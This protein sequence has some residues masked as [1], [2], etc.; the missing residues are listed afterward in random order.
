MY[1]RGGD[2]QEQSTSLVWELGVTGCL[3]WAE[4]NSGWKVTHVTKWLILMVSC[5]RTSVRVGS[6]EHECRS[7][8][9]LAGCIIVNDEA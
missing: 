3:D 8:A 6:P 7:L 1:G 9:R 2:K 4:I 5:D